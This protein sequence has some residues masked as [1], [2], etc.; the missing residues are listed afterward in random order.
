MAQ[1][2]PGA[3]AAPPPQPPVKL[4]KREQ[5]PPEAEQLSGPYGPRFIGFGP[6]PRLP[7]WWRL[8]PHAIGLAGGLAAV[9]WSLSARS[10]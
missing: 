9:A 5:L 4:P 6:V 3:F 10:W 1:V 7:L 8:A 2:I